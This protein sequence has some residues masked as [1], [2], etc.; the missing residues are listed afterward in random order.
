MEITS[1]LEDALSEKAFEKTAQ[2]HWHISAVGIAALWSGKITP[3]KPPF[4]EA[5]EEGLEI[6][7]DLSR[8]CKQFH[9]IK[10]GL[11]ILFTT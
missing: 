9:Q 8:E 6:G 4:N 2:F 5:I 1:I 3:S 10:Q 7:L 11:V